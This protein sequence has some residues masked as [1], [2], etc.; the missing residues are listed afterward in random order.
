MA[1]GADCTPFTFTHGYTIAFDAPHS[2]GVTVGREA[3]VD[4]MID[5]DD[6]EGDSGAMENARRSPSAAAVAGDDH[7]VAQRFGELLDGRRGRFGLV[8]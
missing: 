8:A 5:L 6:D 1:C 7:M 3:A 4:G 2:V